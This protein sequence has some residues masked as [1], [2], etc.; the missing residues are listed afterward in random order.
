MVS[1]SALSA[2][3]LRCVLTPHKVP[4]CLDVPLHKHSVETNILFVDALHMTN[5]LKQISELRLFPHVDR[6]YFSSSW[7]QLSSCSLGT[8]AEFHILPSGICLPRIDH[9][10]AVCPRALSRHSYCT[11]P[12]CT[13]STWRLGSHSLFHIRRQGLEVGE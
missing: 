10:T 6:R 8:T 9:G 12:T 2:H 1:R 4:D 11:G 3:A 5:L 13:R 7:F